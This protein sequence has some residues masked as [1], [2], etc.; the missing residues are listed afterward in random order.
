MDKS[1]NFETIVPAQ[2]K[3]HTN[4]TSSITS[5][6]LS[7]PG[8]PRTSVKSIPSPG[9]SKIKSPREEEIPQKNLEKKE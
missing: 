8:S 9:R 4:I 2:S 1:P 5:P 7:M 3:P 6:K